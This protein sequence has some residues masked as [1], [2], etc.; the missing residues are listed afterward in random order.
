ML[1]L[2]LL[3]VL[4][5]AGGGVIQTTTTTPPTKTTQQQHHSNNINKNMCAHVRNYPWH[6]LASVPTYVN[7]HVD[8]NFA[9][10]N[11]CQ[12]WQ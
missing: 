9:G 4:L 6:H 10:V 8:D 3:L 7:C 2:E 1:V 11:P 12:S 5:C